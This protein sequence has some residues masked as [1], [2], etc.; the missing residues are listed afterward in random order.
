MRR[1][2]DYAVAFVLDEAAHDPEM[3]GV[4]FRQFTNML[5]PRGRVE[6]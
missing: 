3:D 6:R 5:D 2:H 1:P 4:R